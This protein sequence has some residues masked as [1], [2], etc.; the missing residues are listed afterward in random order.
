MSK[1]EEHKVEVA[2]ARRMEEAQAED[3]QA[4]ASM[5]EEPKAEV[6][7]AK[8]PT[9]DGDSQTTL[10]LGGVAAEEAEAEEA[11]AA[12]STYRS[13]EEEKW[14]SLPLHQTIQKELEIEERIALGS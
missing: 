11:E 9:S 14:F 8:E 2:A 7:A 6:A 5:A 3:A 13:D 1:A 4:E 10:V 12:C